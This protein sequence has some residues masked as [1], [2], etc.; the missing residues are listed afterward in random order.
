MAQGMGSSNAQSYE[1]SKTLTQLSADMSSFYNVG[2][3]V[4]S[5]ALSSVF[6]GET[7]SLKQFG[8]VMT[9]TNLQEFARQQGISKTIDQMSQAEQVQ[10]RYQYVLAK[11]GQAQGDF[12]RTST[13]MANSSRI[14]WASITDATAKVFA[15]LLPSVAS[16]MSKIA[17]LAEKFG[18]LPQPVQNA[19]LIIGGLAIIIPPILI[20]IGALIT[21]I[22]TIGTVFAGISAPVV[23]A[24]AGIIATITVLVVAFQKLF[25]TNQA[26]HDTVITLWQG[27][28]DFI[29]VIIID[30]QDIFNTFAEYARVIWALFGDNITNVVRLAFE[31]IMNIISTVLG[32]IKGLFN[33]F[34]ALLKGDWSTFWSSLGQ[35]LMSILSGILNNLRI[36]LSMLGNLFNVAWTAVNVATS[37]RLNEMKDTIFRIVGGV[38][39]WI[40]DKTDGIK[41]F[42]ENMFNFKIPR[43]PLP[44]FSITGSF[45]PLEGKFPSIGVNWYAKGGLFNEPSVI[46]VGERGQEAVVPLT[47]KSTMSLL[48]A[49][50][51]R[52]MPDNNNIST[53]TSGNTE[54]PIYIM[55]QNMAVRDNTDI[56]KIA[57]KLKELADKEKRGRGKN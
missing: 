20:V 5:L 12:A 53:E 42:F 26:F 38:W 41:H 4:T 6:T 16:I 27:I 35:V 17:E 19:I 2:S 52:Y 14:A 56:E 34:T 3:D 49:N 45:S 57:E 24:V 46:G 29:S 18:N 7:E 1:M 44:H 13:G 37:G 50:I 15:V 31:Y 10:L 55:V 30:L 48:G 28:K 51:A 21:A 36:W 47:N 39:S 40:K 43:I 22:G 54:S 11:T 25:T 9:Q 33:A 23:L 32:I 8:I